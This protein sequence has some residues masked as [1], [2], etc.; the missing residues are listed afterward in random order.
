MRFDRVD[1]KTPQP[2][3]PESRIDNKRSEKTGIADPL[4][5]YHGADTTVLVLCKKE[6]AQFPDREILYR[7]I[8]V[9]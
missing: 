2:L 3:V 9:R 1:K 7:Q 8:R 6:V 5:P 4:K